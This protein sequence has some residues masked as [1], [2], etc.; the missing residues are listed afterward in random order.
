M[1]D[2]YGNAVR[3]PGTGD[4]AALA[5]RVERVEETTKRIEENT[6]DLIEV[7]AAA[8]GAFKTLEV[9][10]KIARPIVWIGT[11]GSFVVYAWARFKS[12][13]GDLFN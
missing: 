12:G 4:I 11:V 9:L 5:E 6:S 1:Q 3:Y 13:I 10:G 8:K 2:D 7:L